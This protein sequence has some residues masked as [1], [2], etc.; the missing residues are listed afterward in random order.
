[1]IGAGCVFP[2]L[3]ADTELLSA[4]R[5]DGDLPSQSELDA[6]LSQHGLLVT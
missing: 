3:P 2:P 5:A 1:M 6:A 4:S